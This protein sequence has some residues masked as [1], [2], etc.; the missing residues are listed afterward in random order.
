MPEPANPGDAFV[1]WVGTFIS[2]GL[3]EVV[4][5]LMN[6]SIRWRGDVS[7]CDN[8]RPI[9]CTEYMRSFVPTKCCTDQVL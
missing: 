5:N 2:I 7:V 9:F 6:G 1:T 4:F 8:Y 3:L